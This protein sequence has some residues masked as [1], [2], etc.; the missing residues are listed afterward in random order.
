VGDLTLEGLVNG[1]DLGILLASWGVCTGACASDLNH[2]GVVNGADLG[3]LLNAWG[4]CG[5]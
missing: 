4:T 2:D 3:V 5:D 1:A